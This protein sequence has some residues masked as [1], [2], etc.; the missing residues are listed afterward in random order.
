M[1]AMRRIETGDYMAALDGGWSS[2]NYGFGPSAMPL[3]TNG[4]QELHMSVKFLQP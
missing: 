2:Q 3:L 1:S 4:P